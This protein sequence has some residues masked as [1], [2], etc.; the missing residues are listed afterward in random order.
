MLNKAICLVQLED[1]EE[2]LKLLYQLDFEYADD[3]NVQRVLAGTLTCDNKLEQAEK[4]Y[5]QM[6]N[7]QQVIAEDHLNYGYCLWVMGRIDEA[8]EH[9]RKS[10]TPSEFPDV[11]WLSKR[12]IDEL[13]VRMMTTLV[14]S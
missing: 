8:A 5:G 2:A 11:L 14:H 9:F 7:G 3:V 10:N 12:G 1:Y 4:L 13:Q 6:M